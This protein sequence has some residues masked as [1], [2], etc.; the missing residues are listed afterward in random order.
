M[1]K[2]KDKGTAFERQVVE[3]LKMA[4]GPAI[5]RRALSGTNDR[6]DVSG[7]YFMGE[8]FVLEC[9]NCSRMQL[10][11]WLGELDSE[12][13]NEGTLFGAVVHK[14]RGCGE[15]SF[16]ETY[17]TMPLHVLVRMISLGVE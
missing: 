5:E 8:P 7:V 1:S 11:E 3:Y 13:C 10:A 12:M 15:A 6:G 9:K 17:V 16:G 2:S 14:R 4:L